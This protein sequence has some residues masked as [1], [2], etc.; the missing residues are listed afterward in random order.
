[1]FSGLNERVC[2]LAASLPDA[3]LFPFGMSCA[4]A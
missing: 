4:W 3:C 1:L 2:S